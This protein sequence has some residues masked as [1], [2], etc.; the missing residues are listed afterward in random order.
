M[1]PQLANYVL[2]AS[3]ESANTENM[4]ELSDSW[5]SSIPEMS[6]AVEDLLGDFQEN[7]WHI[8]PAEYY[9]ELFNLSQMTGEHL[10]AFMS[11]ISEE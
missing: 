1:K 7:S 2:V 6:A 3:G 4:A 10:I 5:Y 9:R 11:V 8:F